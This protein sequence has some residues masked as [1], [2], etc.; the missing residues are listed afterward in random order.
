MAM[1]EI[2]NMFNKLDEMYLPLVEKQNNENALNAYYRATENIRRTS[3]QVMDGYIEKVY[4]GRDLNELQKDVQILKLSGQYTEEDQDAEMELFFELKEKREQA[5]EAMKQGKEKLNEIADSLGAPHPCPP[6]VSERQFAAQLVGEYESY[7]DLFFRNFEKAL[8]E[9]VPFHLNE[10]VPDS[11]NL[12]ELAAKYLP[13]AKEAIREGA[14]PRNTFANIPQFV[15]LGTQDFKVRETIPVKKTYTKTPLTGIVPVE[16]HTTHGRVDVSIPV[17]A[18]TNPDKDQTKYYIRK[19]DYEKLITP[20]GIPYVSAD[21][22]RPLKPGEKSPVLFPA[23]QESILKQAGYSVFDPPEKRQEIIQKVFANKQMDK[24][25]LEDY[26][27]GQIN[28]SKNNLKRKHTLPML[29]EDKKF[30]DGLIEQSL[31]KVA[32]NSLE[33]VEKNSG[34]G[35]KRDG[36]QGSDGDH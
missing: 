6:D 5:I 32:V 36:G 18:V 23:A 30:V 13:V 2:E 1:L 31:G 11:K 9:G 12:M 17:L 3:R 34:K 25:N 22:I 16:S 24:A 21:F 8:K 14:E 26:F 20:V 10:H 35:K 4:V 27:R 28:M 7:G 15:S 19:A 33:H 29:E